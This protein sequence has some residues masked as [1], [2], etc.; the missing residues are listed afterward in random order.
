MGTSDKINAQAVIQFIGVSHNHP[1][2]SSSYI[3]TREQFN[4]LPSLF[5]KILKDAEVKQEKDKKRGIVQL[6]H[7][8]IMEGDCGNEIIDMYFEE[9]EPV[10]KKLAETASPVTIEKTYLISTDN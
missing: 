1:G 2:Y 9:V 6:P 10:L 3:L 8:F 5:L 7:V 4:L